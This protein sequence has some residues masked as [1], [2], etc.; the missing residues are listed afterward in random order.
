MRSTGIL[1]PLV[2][3]ALG[4]GKSAET[5]TQPLFK[6]LAPKA[7]GITFANT[8]PT[9]DSINVL[10]NVYLYNGGGVGVGDIDNDG[11]P[12]VFFTGNMVSS[13]LYLNRGNMQ[14]ED[15][16]Q[17]AGVTTSRW[18]SGVSLVDINSDGYLDIYV[19]VSG[20]QWL[21]AENQAYLLF[22]NNGDDTFTVDLS[23][24][25]TRVVRNGV[26]TLYAM[27]AVKS[28][29]VVAGGGNDK[30]TIALDGPVQA[31]LGAGADELAIGATT[32]PCHVP[33][34]PRNCGQVLSSA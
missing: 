6:Q 11:L 17:S 13:R 28:V 31:Y 27:T 16:T 25:N 19:S 33:S 9:S 15:I 4:C 30:V 3:I 12:D 22:I 7:T 8:I 34:G 32:S 20:P 10:T 2:A 18:A 24:N 23:G 1:A 5:T 21:K 29:D 14:F 26:T